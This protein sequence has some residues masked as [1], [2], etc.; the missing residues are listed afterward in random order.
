MNISEAAKD[1]RI[2]KV[3]PI[4]LAVQKAAENLG[5]RAFVIGGYVRDLLIGRPCDDLDIVAEGSGVELAEETG[6]LLNNAKVVVFKRFG[7]AMLRHRGME[8]EFVGARKESYRAD[9]RKPVVENGTLRDDQLRRDFTINALS[10][11]LQKEDFGEIYDPFDGISDLRNGIIR[12]PLDPDTTYSDDPLRMIRGIRFACQ[13]NFRIV[14]ESLASM[15]RNR[16]RLGIL[17]VERITEEMNKIMSSPKPSVGLTLLERTSLLGL[18]LP[19]VSALKGVEEH[20]GKRHKDNFLHTMKVLDNVALQSDSL[21]LRWAALL[22]DI[23]KAVTKKYEPGTGW[24]FYSHNYVG[25][26]MV[27]KITNY[28]RLPFNEMKYVEKLV[29][30]H[31]RPIALVEDEVTDSAV[32]RL[33]FDAGD[34]IDDLMILCGADITSKNEDTVARHKHNFELVKQKLIEVEE[35]DKVR[36]FQPPVTGDMIMSIYGIPPCREIGVIKEYIKNSILDGIIPNEE[37]AAMSLMR[38]KAAELGLKEIR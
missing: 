33:L 38:E 6:K 23:G 35:K 21:W 36:N 27:R 13:L 16:S 7:T 10:F 19:Q 14:P 9:S 24:T 34:D 18:I 4:L 37:E 22:H 3:M 31:M 32:R 1:N 2:G 12:T 5:I 28:L 20:D 29:E 30:L 11:S 25:A 26:K 15:E 17:S 8:V